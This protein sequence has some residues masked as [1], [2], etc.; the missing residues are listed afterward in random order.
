MKY[1]HVSKS[2]IFSGSGALCCESGRW[3]QSARA[4][5]GSRCRVTLDLGLGPAIIEMRDVWSCRLCFQRVALPDWEKLI[6]FSWSS[7]AF[8]LENI[9]Y[10][11]CENFCVFVLKFCSLLDAACNSWALAQH[12]V[13][14][15][16]CVLKTLDSKWINPKKW[17]WHSNLVIKLTLNGNKGQ[18][19]SFLII[20]KGIL[21]FDRLA[22]ALKSSAFCQ[23]FRLI[24]QFL[25]LCVEGGHLVGGVDTRYRTTGHRH[26]SRLGDTRGRIT[27]TAISIARDNAGRVGWRTSAR[28]R[29]KRELCVRAGPEL[30]E[31]CRYTI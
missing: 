14:W 27:T 20:P 17:S 25:L 6:L 24:T 9:Y 16:R 10:Y 15:V 8:F 4:S 18:R 11:K 5:T 3:D 7:F 31:R 26:V 21:K 30:R 22:K 12:L 29:H 13:L 28:L 19:Y 1:R 2:W 23:P